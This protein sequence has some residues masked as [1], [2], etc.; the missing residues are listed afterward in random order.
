[1]FGKDLISNAVGFWITFVVLGHL[2]CFYRRIVIWRLHKQ[3]RTTHAFYRHQRKELHTAS[4]FIIL[5][6]TF[7]TLLVYYVVLALGHYPE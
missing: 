5:A 1:M 6:A 2:V 3:G 4:L 7:I